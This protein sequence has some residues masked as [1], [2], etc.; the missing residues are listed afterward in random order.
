LSDRP[1]HVPRWY[2]AVLVVAPLAAEAQPAGKVPRVGYLSSGSS[3]DPA[4]QRRFEAF[5]Q[6]LLDLGYVEGRNVALEPR[7]AGAYDEYP[8]LAAELIRLKADVIVALGGSATQA[9]QQAT[10]TIPIVM[11]VV[12]DPLVADLWLASRAPEETSRGRR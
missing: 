8:V 11:S 6:G 2:R 7:W 12:I 1:S 4:R 5:R 10:R 3:S 9:V